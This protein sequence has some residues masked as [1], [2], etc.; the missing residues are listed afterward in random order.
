MLA[1]KTAKQVSHKAIKTIENLRGKKA[2]VKVRT[3]FVRLKPSLDSTII[4]KAPFGREMEIVEQ[5]GEW[6]KI[7]YKFQGSARNNEAKNDENQMR[8]IDG[9]VARRLLEILE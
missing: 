2:R 6:V 9:Y 8:N 7:H 3:A 4:A 1:D 5:S